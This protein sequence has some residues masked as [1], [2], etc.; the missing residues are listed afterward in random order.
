MKNAPEKIYADRGPRGG[1]IYREQ[2]MPD[3]EA[4]Y[5]RAD[6][7][8]TLAA[9]N[10]RLTVELAGA[11]ER[12]RMMLD[13]KNYWKSRAEARERAEKAEAE[14]E[15]LKGAASRALSLIDQAIGDTD[16]SDPDNQLLLAAQALASA[17]GEV[18]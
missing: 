9:E 14:I 3:T 1:L 2:R 18:A 4:E 17:L 6:L 10:E 11:N 5:V 15:R 8:A 16:P 13:A 7:H 12:A